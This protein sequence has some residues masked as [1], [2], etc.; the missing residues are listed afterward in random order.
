VSSRTLQMA[1][2]YSVS[3]TEKTMVTLTLIVLCIFF[4]K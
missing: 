1:L 2:V 3:R 4:L